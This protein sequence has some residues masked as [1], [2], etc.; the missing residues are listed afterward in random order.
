MRDDPLKLLALLV[1]G[2]VDFILIGGVAA[3][4]HGSSLQTDDLDIV[5]AMETENLKRLSK[6]LAVTKARFR[7]QNPPIYFTEEMAGR[8]GW[9]NLYLETDL[10]V[11]DCL[12]EVKGIGSYEDC[13]AGIVEVELGEIVVRLLNVE[14]LIRAKEA[15]GRPKD[16]QAV[17]QL[18]IANGLATEPEQEA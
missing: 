2:E 4:I 17:A 11:L 1:G 13:S 7:H 8:A 3:R 14:F 10:G 9:K 5:I 18:R 12:G 16:L 6:V 15:V